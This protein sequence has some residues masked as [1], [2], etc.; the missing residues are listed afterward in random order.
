MAT[1]VAL[2][3]DLTNTPSLRK[4]PQWLADAAAATAAESGLTVRIW[5]DQELATAGF[6]GSGRG[7]LR[8]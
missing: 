4:S 3:R 6:G 2:A 5:S 8:I 1:A 7:R